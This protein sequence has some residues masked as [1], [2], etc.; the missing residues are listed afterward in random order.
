M[1]QYAKDSTYS[2]DTIRKLFPILAQSTEYGTLPVINRDGVLLSEL[3]GYATLNEEY[4]VQKVISDYQA[5]KKAEAAAWRLGVG[6]LTTF[7]GL[8]NGFQLWDALHGFTAGMI[9]GKVSDALQELDGQQLKELGLEWV[10]NPSS[11]LYHRKRHRGDAVRRL[12]ML[13]PHPQ[14]GV[15]CTSFGIQFPDGYVAHLSF[16]PQ[17]GNSASPVNG[18]FCTSSNGF[19]A[20]LLS[21]RQLL[22]MIICDSGQQLPVEFWSDGS[23]NSLVAI[24]YKAPHHSIY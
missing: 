3:I 13:L 19:D 9:A 4:V 2:E 22:G 5:K 14:T 8:G 23:S 10:N 12:L 1:V 24:P 11:Y 6:L 20:E 16:M 7:M 15:R 18:L 21:H 17:Q